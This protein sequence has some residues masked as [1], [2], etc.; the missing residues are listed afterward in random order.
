MPVDE[1]SLLSAP[2]HIKRTRGTS[3]CGQLGSEIAAMCEHN[4][5][6][7]EFK[8]RMIYVIVFIVGLNWTGEYVRGCICFFWCVV[9]SSQVYEGDTR[10]V[11]FVEPEVSSC[12]RC[13]LTFSLEIFLS[14]ML[15]S[16]K[17]DL[18][19]TTSFTLKEKFCEETCT[20]FNGNCE[21]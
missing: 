9:L 12:S 5:S 10:A 3:A 1:S 19:L 16:A 7:M 8:I 6:G 17:L 18:A 21:L 2:L 20:A 4:L 15:L 13:K 11:K 14:R